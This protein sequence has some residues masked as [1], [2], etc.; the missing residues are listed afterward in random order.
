MSNKKIDL[1]KDNELKIYSKRKKTPEECKLVS[2]VLVP[3][4]DKLIKTISTSED[5]VKHAIKNYGDNDLQNHI[6][7]A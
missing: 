1:F 3:I 6:S 5:A 7:D 2:D 4:N